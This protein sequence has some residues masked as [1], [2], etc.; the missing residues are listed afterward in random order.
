MSGI[1]GIVNLDGR[2]VEESVLAAMSAALA[3]RGPDGSGIW[4][5]GAV[6]L[7]HRMLHSTPESLHETQ[8]LRDETGQLCLVLDGRIDNREELKA[9]IEAAGG[10]LRDG[11]DAEL[12]LQSYACWAEDCPKHLFGDFAFAIWDG[13]RRRLF[14]ARDPLG[15]KP[16]FYRCDGKTF[17]F[18]SEMQPLFADPQF[19]P[20]VNLKL[21]GMFLC[22]DYGDFTETLYQDVFRL[23]PAH[24]GCVE[25][26]ALRKF[27]Y[28]DVDPGH[29]LS[30]SADAEYTEHFLHLFRSSVRANLRAN[31][32][33]A[34]ALSGGL[35]SSSIV[36]TAAALARDGQTPNGHLMAFSQFYPGLPCDESEYI[37]EVAR[38][39]GV[40]AVGFANTADPSATDFERA[41]DYPDVLYSITRHMFA[42]AMQQMQRR[43]IR[44]LLE[45]IGGDEVLVSGFSHLAELTRRGKWLAMMRQLRSDAANYSRTPSWLLMNQVIKPLVPMPVKD[46][47]RPLVRRFRRQEQEQVPLVRPDFARAQGIYEQTLPLPQFPTSAQQSLYYSIFYGWGVVTCEMNQL[48]SSRF[49]V[50]CRWP[51]LERRL[52][53]F[54]LAVPQEQRWR[55]D[56]SKFLLRQAMVGILP[57]KLRQRKHKA[58]F[59]MVFDQ[60]LRHRQADKVEALFRDSVLVALGVGDRGR[61]QQV[62]AEYRA[63]APHLA[64]MVEFVVE[65]ELFCRAAHDRI[66][67]T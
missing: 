65:L 39:W 14:C 6:G 33:V 24:C 21:L 40:E 57:E 7:V 29:S 30:Y 10:R 36:C 50:E 3:H 62:L 38:R 37:H 47:L 5:D 9:A 59:T 32:T 43:G 53:E 19:S 13:R 4:R 22:L 42:P 56:E 31:G 48:F 41:A 55:G 67:R 64:T 18:A 1:A 8:P 12:V 61:F 26:G 51:F 23:S 27:R 2:P 16:F 25:S 44:V 58:S 66:A 15:N 28:W 20:R 34:A 46:V 52:V 35:D 11:T 54:L 45:G 63:G 17:A 49:G 60:E